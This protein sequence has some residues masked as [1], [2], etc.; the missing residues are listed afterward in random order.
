MYLKEKSGRI[1]LDFTTLKKALVFAGLLL[2]FGMQGQPKD[3]NF[4]IKKKNLVWQDEFDYTGLP[5]S[6]K[7]DYEEG[8]I[9]KPE[10]QYYTRERLKNVH[11]A[12]GNLVITACKEEFEGARYTS[13]SINTKGKFEFIYGRVEVRAKLPK[14]RGVFPAIWM[15]GTNI[16]QVSWPFCGEI[17]IMEYW[18]GT[19]PNEI[20]STVHTRDYSWKTNNGRGSW[21]N[22]DKPWEDFHIYA[23]EWYYDRLDFYFEDK[24]FFTCKKKGEGIGEWPFDAPQYLLINFALSGQ[25]DIDDSIFPINFL[26][27]YVRIYRLE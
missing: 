1:K 7:W 5:D 6:K 25:P 12:N 16:D 10:P 26:V 18:G 8:M 23:V 15:L 3:E 4:Q 22:Y 11:V 24:M 14:G 13:A 19:H 21:F 20:K 17:D 27:D 2:P 9:R